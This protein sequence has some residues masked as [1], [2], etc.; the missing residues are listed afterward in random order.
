MPPDFSQVRAVYFDLD[1]TLCAYWD[2]SK[3][4]LFK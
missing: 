4:A 2:A 1:D 3:I